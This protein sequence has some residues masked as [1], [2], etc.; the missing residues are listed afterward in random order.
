MTFGRGVTW[1][2]GGPE[3]DLSSLKENRG[4]TRENRLPIG[5]GG[6]ITR[7]LTTEPS[8][9]SGKFYSD[10][11]RNLRPSLPEDK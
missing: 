1:F 6:E 5:G 3:G 9:R 7:I 8:G 2:L 11:T 10:A 4:G